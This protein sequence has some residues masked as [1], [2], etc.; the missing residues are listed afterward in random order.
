MQPRE[1]SKR[2]MFNPETPP[3]FQWPD[4]P[5]DRYDRGASWDFL[6]AVGAGA[7]AELA[8]MAVMIILFGLGL[9]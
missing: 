9:V 5:D 4:I 3:S 7:A 8:L 6:L 1:F 2:R